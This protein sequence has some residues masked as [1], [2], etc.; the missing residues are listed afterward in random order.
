M[1]FLHHPVQLH[2]PVNTTTSATAK[3]NINFLHK[4]TQ[5]VASSSYTLLLLKKMPLRSTKR[6]HY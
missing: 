3:E 2:R 6:T 5:M 4:T 1:T